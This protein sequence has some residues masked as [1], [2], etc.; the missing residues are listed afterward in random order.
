M[1]LKQLTFAGALAL[2][3]I[4]ACVD[5]PTDEVATDEQLALGSGSGSGS[6]SACTNPVYGNPMYLNQPLPVACDT[7]CIGSGAGYTSETWRLVASRYTVSNTC[8]LGKHTGVGVTDST[9]TTSLWTTSGPVLHTATTAWTPQSLVAAVFNHGRTVDPQAYATAGTITL[10]YGGPNSSAIRDAVNTC[11][12]VAMTDGFCDRMCGNDAYTIPPAALVDDEQLVDGQ[13]LLSAVQ[14]FSNR[15]TYGNAHVVKGKWY[16]DVGMVACMGTG[17]DPK[18]VFPHYGHNSNTD[19]N[20][21]QTMF[22]YCN[23]VKNTLQSSC[24]VSD[25]NVGLLI[26]RYVLTT[27][28]DVCGG[29]RRAFWDA[30]AHLGKDQLVLNKAL[31]DSNLTA[32]PSTAGATGGQPEAG[33]LFDGGWGYPVNGM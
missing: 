26:K 30:N 20:A 1:Q 32:A 14:P 23:T 18:Q 31:P 16:A 5:E 11:V 13:W 22:N 9:R 28:E 17:I 33:S 4:A 10:D 27:C 24:D 21:E 25:A 6:G 29:N 19:A 7:S 2:S 8:S 3:S 12:G 15:K